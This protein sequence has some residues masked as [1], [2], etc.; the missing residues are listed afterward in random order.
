MRPSGLDP[1]AVEPRNRVREELGAAAGTPADLRAQRLL[2]V[3]GHGVLW[4]QSDERA[5]RQPL[6]PNSVG[7]QAKRGVRRRAR[8]TPR[9]SA[10]FNIAW[11]GLGTLRV[12]DSP[13]AAA[14]D[15]LR[16]RES[17]VGGIS[18]PYTER[19][20]PSG[21]NSPNRGDFP[22]V[23]AP[24]RSRIGLR[25]RRLHRLPTSA[26]RRFARRLKWA[27]DEARSSAAGASLDAR[28]GSLSEEDLTILR[29]ALLDHADSGLL[30]FGGLGWR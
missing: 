3:D 25:R 22:R 8:S 12:P 1:G 11:A 7:A 14:L 24:S 23:P 26:K 2:K 21:V 4:C 16:R 29:I 17:R 20:D 27:F 18:I 13:P 30:S 6:A 15:G 9:Q 19:P 5:G 28:A 10:M